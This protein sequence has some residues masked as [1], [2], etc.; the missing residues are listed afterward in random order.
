MRT[1]F[2]VLA[3][4][5]VSMGTLA[6]G[7]ADSP[8]AQL[9]ALFRD[10]WEFDLVEDP[11]LA[12]QVG[13][14]RF[15][16]RLP[17][18]RPS[19]HERRLAAEREFLARWETI[20]RATLAPR[21]RISY[22]IFG[23]LK[24]EAIAEYEFQTHLMPITN[25]EGFHVFFPELGRDVPLFTTADYE[26]FVAR[27]TLFDEYA[28][29]HVELMRAGIQA[30]MVLPE[31]VLRDA[32]KPI[33]DQIVGDPAASPL[34]RPFENFPERV[35]EEDRARLRSGGLAAIA[36]HVVPGYRSFHEFME[37]EYLPAARDSIAATTLPRGREFY[38]HRVARFTT[39]SVTPDEVHAVGLAEVERIKQEM[40]TAIANAG[41][42][43]TFAGFVEYLRNDPRFYVDSPQALLKEVAL[44]LKRMD[45]ELPR[46]FKRLPRAPYGIREIP[47]FIAPKTT[48]A[49]YSPATGDGSRAG[50]YYVNTYD[51]ASRPL[52]EI[53]AL[54]LHE[55]VPGHHLQIAIAQEL[56]DVPDFQRFNGATAFVEGWALYSERLGLEV[57]FYED[58]YSDF[59]RLSYEMWRACR[60][61]VDTGM[62]YLGWSREQAIEFMADN[63]A[64]TRRN[65]VSEVD[66]YL[67]WP[68]QALAYKMGELAFRRLR[69]QAMERLGERFDVREFHDVVLRNGAVPL[70][71]LERVVEDWLGEKDEG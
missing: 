61:V 32:L 6:R 31:V 45:G 12:T 11:L 58:P 14:H 22:D 44:V 37:R 33:A 23:R 48:T 46:L 8:E 55:A 67:S 57:G 19:D 62:H 54:S 60:L 18:V 3:A 2:V 65:I 15:D 25:R 63:T 38:R 40:L 27:L 29:E 20:D 13:D 69:Q 34:A 5:S 10:S 24:R 68:G 9:E 35:P 70:E 17:H 47:A 26:H 49:Y 53:E 56:S 4:A 71:V 36:K 66:R 39:L 50:F 52:Y 51:L 59:G 41:F 64:L 7:E 28:A 16:D 42:K 43:G 21:Q 30:G 1:A